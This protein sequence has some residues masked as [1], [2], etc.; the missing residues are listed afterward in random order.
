MDTCAHASGN[1]YVLNC[2]TMRAQGFHDIDI[3]NEI[4]KHQIE[5]IEVIQF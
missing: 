2:L 1:L 3:E 4:D 5:K